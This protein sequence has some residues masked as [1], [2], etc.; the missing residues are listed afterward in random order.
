MNPTV[1]HTYSGS[2]VSQSIEIYFQNGHIAIEYRDSG[3]VARY[4]KD[5]NIPYFKTRYGKQG[6]GHTYFKIKK[7][8]NHT[9]LAPGLSFHDLN[10]GK[11]V[12]PMEVNNDLSPIPISFNI[13]GNTNFHIGG[14]ATTALTGSSYSGSLQ[15]ITFKGPEPFMNQG[16]IVGVCDATLLPQAVSPQVRTFSFAKPGISV[17]ILPGS[18]ASDMNTYVIEA[19]GWQDI[20]ASGYY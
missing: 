19:S 6:N 8:K 20:G 18:L 7:Q 16:Q 13:A 12:L 3:R 10:I 5:L 14:T 15:F 4:T 17:E 1:F 11:D 9:N 2:F